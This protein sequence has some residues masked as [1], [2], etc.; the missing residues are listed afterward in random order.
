MARPARKKAP[1]PGQLQMAID[2]IPAAPPRPT[3]PPAP[4][5]PPEA[6][7]RSTYVEDRYAAPERPAFGAWLLKQKGKGGLVGQLADGAAAD[8]AF[9]KGGDVEAVRARLRAVMADGDMYEAVDDAESAWL[10]S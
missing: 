1:P 3:S 7:P 8:R 4:V 10:A 2:R 9:P 6:P 5:L